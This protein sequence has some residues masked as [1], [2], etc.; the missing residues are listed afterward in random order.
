M[1]SD[2]NG[3]EAQARAAVRL[4]KT[5]ERDAQASEREREEAARITA[6]DEKMARLKALRL[7]REAQ[8][9]DVKK[10]K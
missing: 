10:A 2:R 9:A 8:T 1:T 4:F 3:P 7:E 5:R 6:I